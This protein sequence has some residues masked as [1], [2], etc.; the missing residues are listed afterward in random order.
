MYRKTGKYHLP[1]YDAMREREREETL[2]KTLN[3]LLLGLLVLASIWHCMVRGCRTGKDGKS[4]VWPTLGM[5]P[6]GCLYICT[7]GASTDN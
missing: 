7:A 2:D 5:V 6:L 1:A 3:L 4:L